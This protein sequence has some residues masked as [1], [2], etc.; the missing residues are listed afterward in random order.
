[1]NKGKIVEYID[2]GNFICTICMEDT[3]TRLHLLTS[4]N[5][6]INLSPKRALLVST[7]TLDTL[8]PR[9]HLLSTLKQTD[10]LRERLKQAFQVKE[11]WELIKD[12]EESFDYQYLAELCFGEKVTDDHIS[13]LVRALFEDKLHFKMKDGRFLPNS[14]ERVNEILRQRE[15]EAIREERLMRES[16]WLKEVL[17]G[18]RTETPECEKQVMDVL[19]ELALLG[20]EAPNL[21]YGKELLQR[22]GIG[23]VNEA[24]GIL[25]KLSFWEEDENL[26]L[27]RLDIKRAFGEEE[28]QESIAL[29]G[30]EISAED[31]ED[32]RYLDA[33]TIDGPLTRDFDDA[34]SIDVRED[35]IHV[36]VHIADVTGHIAPGSI[37]DREACLRGSSL[38]LPRQQIAMI[39]P[40]LSQ[41]V[42]SLKQDRDR[43]ALSLLC[44]F[45]RDGNLLDYRFT[46]SVIRVRRQLEYDQVNDLYR[47]ESALEQIYR[48]SLLLRE[49]RVQQG[50]II[51]SLPEVAVRFESDGGIDLELI[52]Q[53]TPSRIIVAEFMIL[54]NWLGARF[55]RDQQIPILYRCQ[56]EP[57][58]RLSRAE[59][60]DDLH[61]IFKQRRKLNPLVITT[62]PGPHAGLGLDVYT[63]VSS[64]IRR[65]LDL[66]VQ[67]QIKSLLQKKPPAYS[68]E[69]LEEIRMGVEPLLKD[70]ERLKRNRIRYW[71]LKHLQQH[72]GKSFSALVLYSMKSNYRILLTDFL[73]IAHMRREEGLEFSEGDRIRVKVSKS[74]PWNDLLKVEYFGP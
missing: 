20:D 65:Y 36:G 39:P 24:R 58:E 28:L 50:A 6:E 67:R 42:L 51:L 70:L 22:A 45:A 31:A 3:G 4:S 21:S 17:Q 9:E 47:G 71:T 1:M 60:G 37:L 38:Y 15:Q 59:V 18:R 66:V 54:Y 44:H 63:N 69:A 32:L 49:R 30:L 14:Q 46:P 72:L 2:Q 29:A 19:M 61:Y 7:G 43:R 55:C 27:L 33:M 57:G 52:E 11:L 12:E 64:P 62:Q 10:A 23:N 53:E 68:K 40:N 13:A 26:D 41:D 74:D 5:R 56:E 73:L 48:L 16:A 8:G 34:L 25:V 35:G